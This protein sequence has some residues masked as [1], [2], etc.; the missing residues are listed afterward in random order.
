M[1]PAPT[2]G[3]TRLVAPWRT[4]PTA[5]TPGR[6]VSRNNGC[7]A[8]FRSRHVDARQQ[9]ALRIALDLLGQPFGV[10][11]AADHHEQGRRVDLLLG[12][13]QALPAG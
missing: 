2:D 5:K 11:L 6:L 10:R 13:G 12:A 1:A 8:A 4:S 3:A 9:V 7:R